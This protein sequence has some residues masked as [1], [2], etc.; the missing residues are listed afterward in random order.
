MQEFT[1]TGVTVYDIR[2]RYV[3]ANHL[4]MLD[5]IWAKGVRPDP[6]I[7]WSNSAS[8]N[9]SYDVYQ[10]LKI[11]V[12]SG[13]GAPISGATV[14]CKN[15]NG[16]TVFTQTT[17]ADGTFTAQNMLRA[18]FTYNGGTY[19]STKTD[20]NPFTIKISKADYR[21]ERITK[22]ITEKSNWI[23]TLEPDTTGKILIEEIGNTYV[24]VA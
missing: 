12:V 8:Y 4:N 24:Q 1:S 3:C 21:D 17:D 2:D 11:T 5:C 16:D 18:T 19:T 23:V 9:N 6:V 7:W 15:V 10:S 20:K 14:T 13:A 22:T